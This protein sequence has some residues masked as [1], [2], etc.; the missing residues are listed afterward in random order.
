M[1]KHCLATRRA[2]DLD[3]AFENCAKAGCVCERFHL[4]C[5]S[6]G[7]HRLIRSNQTTSRAEVGMVIV[8][9]TVIA[10]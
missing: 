9:C 7:K 4:L 3:R 10:Q 5:G 6:L 8:K 2:Q 1:L